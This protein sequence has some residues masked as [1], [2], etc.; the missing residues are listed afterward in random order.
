M[1]VR[2]AIDT[3]I[4]ATQLRGLEV[5]AIQ[6]SPDDAKALRDSYGQSLWDT[7]NDPRLPAGVSMIYNGVFVYEL[8]GGGSHL[9]VGRPELLANAR[10]CEVVPIR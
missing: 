4:R 7:A 3:A 8:A 10:V 1:S 6:L 9:L 5:K 2:L